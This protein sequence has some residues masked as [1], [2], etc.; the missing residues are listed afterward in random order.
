MTNQ[1]NN[2][3]VTVEISSAY[4]NDI[5]IFLQYLQSRKGAAA[6][7]SHM[8]QYSEREIDNLYNSIET[9]Q[10]TVLKSET[11]ML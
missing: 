9:F 6:F 1:Y 4:L 7:S 2:N 10:K 11:R 3:I 8:N 5:D